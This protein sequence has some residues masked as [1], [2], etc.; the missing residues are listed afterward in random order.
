MLD[1]VSLSEDEED[2]SYEEDLFLQ[3]FPSIRDH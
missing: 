3:T 2:V 1:N